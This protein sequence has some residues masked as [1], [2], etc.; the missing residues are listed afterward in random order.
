VALLIVFFLAWDLRAVLTDQQI[1]QTDTTV[2][3]ALFCARAS[4]GG[5][6]AALE[7]A[8]GNKKGPLAGVLVLALDRVIGDPLL[9]AR[10]LGVL[11]HGLLLWLVYHLAVSLSGRWLCGAA[12][13]TLCGV[14]FGTY[15]WFRLEF[16]DSL[17]AVFTLAALWRMT[18]PLQRATS[19]VL[20]G[21][22]VGLGLLSKAA[23]P[24]FVC[25]PGLWFLHWRARDRRGLIGLAIA[26]GVAAA[27]VAWWLVPALALLWRYAGLSSATFGQTWLEKLWHN[28]VDIP[29]T[30][31]FIAL[32]LLGA[33][34]AARQGVA[35]A[36]P[37]ILLCLSLASG[38]V[39]LVLVFDPWSRYLLPLFPV[40]ALLVAF[41]VVG[42]AE[43]AARRWGAR[44]TRAVLLL[45]LAAL[46]GR[47]CY[48]N[49]VGLPSPS[50]ERTSGAGMVAPD[51][52]PH[53]AYP[54]M[55]A[56]LRASGLS[57]VDVPNLLPLPIAAVWARRGHRLP[58]I[59]QHEA[60]QRVRRGRPFELLFYHMAGTLSS[61]IQGNPNLAQCPPAM[62]EAARRWRRVVLRSFADPDGW[63]VSLVRFQP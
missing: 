25:V 56:H 53:L 50:G 57:V 60:E 16:H 58:V 40:A 2:E 10:V 21:A 28:S 32:A 24:V 43:R 27:I 51:G 30:G 47:F 17:L 37:L 15:G 23:F 34:L 48:D 12:A 46:I 1:S 4:R 45:V 44:P 26:G 9:A 41:G 5:P 20:L 54:R 52:R 55:V 14:H 6:R 59:L 62:R 36:R 18:Q 7:W 8:W 29:G 39:A 63:R 33:W 13:V 35:A 49:F 22:T 19:G 61:T 3:D 42:L 31:P 38:F 11:M